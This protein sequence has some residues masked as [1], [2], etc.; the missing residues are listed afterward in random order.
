M[1]IR[2]K[3]E[4]FPPGAAV[5]GFDGVIVDHR[6][7]YQAELKRRGYPLTQAQLNVNVIKQHVPAD[8]L[9]DVDAWLLGD[10]TKSAPAFPGALE[11][12]EQF[13][14]AIFIATA[15]GTDERRSA[16]SWLNEHVPT[17]SER[18]VVFFPTVAAKAKALREEELSVFVDDQIGPVKSLPASTVRLLF[19][20]DAALEP[21]RFPDIRIVKN[22][23]E[24]REVIQ[25][26]VK[27]V[28]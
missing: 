10:G 22:W 28:L 18:N 4:T 17:F 27:P 20:P 2:R 26:T 6:K 24:I 11:T 13:R 16:L 19:D 14:D 1:R 21:A 12:L 5:L 15:R 23:D 3:S 9:A 7:Q 8:V 25:S